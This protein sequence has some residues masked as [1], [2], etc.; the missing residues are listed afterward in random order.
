MLRLI[1][2]LLL[3]SFHSAHASNKL[4]EGVATQDQELISED[5]EEDFNHN[6]SYAKVQIL[7]K[8][9]AKTNYLNIKV[10]QEGKIDSI[11]I[12]VDACW[13]SSPYELSENKIL[14]DISEKKF[15]SNEYVKVFRGWMFSSSPSIS[16]MEHPVYDVVAIN[17][18]D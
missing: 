3:L 5:L 16:T 17:C 1:F 2:I 4:K 8:I 7:N 18:Y 6:K 14:L 11:K 12:Y 13:Q 9:T 10:G 15:N